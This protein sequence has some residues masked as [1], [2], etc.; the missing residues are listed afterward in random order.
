MDT[1]SLQTLS[2]ASI[3]IGVILA[4]LGGLGL[5]R[6]GRTV[7]TQQ[8]AAP[9]NDPGEADLRARLTE[10]RK[11]NVEL[12]ERLAVHEGDKTP[13]KKSATVPKPAAKTESTASA[14]EFPRPVPVKTPPPPALAEWAGA[15]L[16]DEMIETSVVQQEPGGHSA[17][18]ERQRRTITAI[19][20][21]YAGHA[22]TIH[23]VTDD[24]AGFNLAWALKAAFAEAG[25]RVEGFEQV[26]YTSPPAGLFITSGPTAAPENAIIPHE[27][28][29]TAG[30][31]VSRCVD[32][33]LKGGKTVLLVGVERK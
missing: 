12:Q 23:S 7:G 22:I 9:K 19:L 14:K 16:L 1:E 6:I 8:P 10:L 5:Y 28:L 18:S 15:S 2:A 27:A 24:N 17:L 20:R 3:L 4:G 26:P 11:T 21:K 33:N 32:S 13:A 30:F 29:I 31:E 25:W